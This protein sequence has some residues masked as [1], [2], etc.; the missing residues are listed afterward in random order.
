[1]LFPESLGL[2]PTFDADAIRRMTTAISIEGSINRR[3]DDPEGKY[4]LSIGDRPAGTVV[5]IVAGTFQVKGLKTLP[6]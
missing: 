6:E 2:A 1:L 5:P 3:T 4:S